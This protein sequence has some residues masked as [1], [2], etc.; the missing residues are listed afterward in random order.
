MERIKREKAVA[1]RM[2]SIYCHRH[3]DT[4]GNEICEECRALLEYAHQRLDRCPHGNRKPSCRKCPIHCYSPAYRERMKA[5]MRYV[6]PRMLFIDPAS[7]IRH[8]ISELKSQ[9]AVSS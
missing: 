6:G 7:A 4:S 5:V 2:I 8:L 1:A 9:G 3:H